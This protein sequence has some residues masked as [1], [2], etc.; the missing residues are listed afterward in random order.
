[1]ELLSV[2]ILHREYFHNDFDHATYD[3]LI[4]VFA[5]E[6]LAKDR[7][8]EI[9]VKEHPDRAFETL[10]WANNK[11]SKVIETRIRGIDEYKDTYGNFFI[12]EYVVHAQETR[13]RNRQ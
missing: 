2:F 7:A 13:A 9:Y 10:F 3:D 11:V 12:K 8:Q 1:M 4:D 5:N 6:Q